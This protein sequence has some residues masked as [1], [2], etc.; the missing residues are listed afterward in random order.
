MNQDK[1]YAKLSFFLGLGCWIPLLG[2]PLSILA[3]VYGITALKLEHNYP[4]RYGGRI[5]AAIGIILGAS[6]IILLVSVFVLPITRQKFLE[7][8]IIQNVTSLN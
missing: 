3:I 2:V 4:E 8:F 1:F 6:S 5:Y 7:T